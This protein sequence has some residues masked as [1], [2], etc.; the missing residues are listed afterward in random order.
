[1]ACFLALYNTIYSQDEHYLATRIKPG[2]ICYVDGEGHER[3]IGYR[4]WDMGNPP[5]DPIGVVFFSFY[6]PYPPGTDGETG[7]HGWMI[8][9]GESDSCVWAPET[10]PCYNTTVARYAVT[11]VSTPYNPHNNQRNHALADTCGWQNTYRMLEFLYAGQGTTLSDAT[12]PVLRYVFSAKNG[13][14]DF[15]VKPSMQERS[16]YLPSLGQLR[17]LYDEI[18]AVNKALAACGGVL[19]SEKHSWYSSSEFQSPA[20][21]AWAVN[22]RGICAAGNMAKKHLYKY[23]RAVRNY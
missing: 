13:V 12:L 9:L 14:S 6:G 17:L 23:V 16:W 10:S 2:D 22:G 15:S 21:A 19:M 7:W 20:N 4:D 18:G 1:M 11:G 5:G 8:E 3:F